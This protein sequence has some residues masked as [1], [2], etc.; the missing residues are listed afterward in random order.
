MDKVGIRTIVVNFDDEQLPYLSLVQGDAKTRGFDIVICDSDGKEIPPSNDYIVELVAT[1]S[2]NPDTPYANRHTVKD[3]KYRVMIPTEALSESGFVFL[4]LVFYQKSTGAVIH[5]IEQK[6][7]VYRSRGQEVVESNNLYVDITALRLGI[8]KIAVMETAYLQV[9][10]DEETRKSSENARINNEQTRVEAETQRVD[11]EAI[12]VSNENTRVNNENLRVTAEEE[13]EIKF[14]SWD[15]TMQGV[16]PNATD[17][18]KGAVKISSL[19]SETEPY[20]AVSIGKL[21][22]EKSNILRD[23]NLLEN[24]VLDNETQILTLDKEISSVSLWDKTVA[25][26]GKKP[27]VKEEQYAFY[28]EVS[29]DNLIDGDSLALKIGL[30]SGSSQNR[31]AGWL[32]FLYKGKILFVAKK[33]LRINLSWDDINS[34]DAVYGDTIVEIK[35][36]N[37]KVRL[38]RGIGEDVQPD[39][40]IYQEKYAGDACHYSEWNNLFCP[41]SE[42]APSLWQYPDNVQEPISKLKKTYTNIELDM[43]EP[44]SWCQEACGA[45]RS[46]RGGKGVSHANATSSSSTTEGWRPVLELVE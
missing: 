45:G 8:E 27:V 44:S 18:E 31:Y 15:K 13:R 10:E 34:V 39:P 1:A 17:T 38:L 11:S 33:K 7:P 43:S 16:I 37:Y 30:S 2:N 9:L 25:P 21:D 24:K 35:G 4:Q 28:G 3:G 40:S 23:V 14:D 19:E 12:R 42:E 5:T 46:Y 6:C 36:L 22:E 29:T 26:G 20:T 32:K 41:I